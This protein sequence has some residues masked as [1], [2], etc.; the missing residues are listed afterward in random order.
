MEFNSCAKL[1]ND[2]VEIEQIYNNLLAEGKDP[3][4]YMLDMQRSLQ[5]KLADTYPDRA[6]SPGDLKKL[7]DIYEWVR[8]QKTAIDDEFSELISA[9]PGMDMPEKQRTGIWKKWR[10]NYN[11]IRNKTIDELTKDEL[12]ELLFEKV[13]IAHFDMNIDLAIGL[14]AKTKFIL[15]VLKNLENVR[16]YNSG[17]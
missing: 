10:A 12:L 15:Y 3:Q 16:R 4:Q 14:D 13:D 5:N 2:Y 7:G 1:V 17:Y 11:E 6:K 9:L 8:D